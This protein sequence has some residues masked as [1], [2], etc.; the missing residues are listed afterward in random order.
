MAV[1]ANVGINL[2]ATL[3]GRQIEGPKEFLKAPAHIRQRSLILRLYRGN[4]QECAETS[5]HDESQLAHHAFSIGLAGAPPGTGPPPRPP[6]TGRL[7]LSG[8]GDVRSSLP[9]NGRI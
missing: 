3:G 1:G 2:K 5:G 4:G 9:S 8:S 6:K 7:M